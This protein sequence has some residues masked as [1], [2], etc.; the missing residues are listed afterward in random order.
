MLTAEVRS[1]LHSI[2]V[3]ATYDLVS[4][5]VILSLAILFKSEL[6][7]RS[8]YNVVQSRSRISIVW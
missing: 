1:T 8:A 2:D 5:S 3:L 4:L 7:F 6:V